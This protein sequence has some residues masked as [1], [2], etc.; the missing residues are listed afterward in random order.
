MGNESSR[1]ET[2]A[3]LDPEV[4]PRFLALTGPEH[5]G[6]RTY[7]LSLLSELLDESDL[8]VA[9]PGPDGARE[10]RPFL[11][12]MPS[13]SPFRAV[14]LDDVDFLSEP[15]QD[16]W[17]KLCE[18]PPGQ[19]CIVAVASDLSMVLPALRSRVVREIRWG[20]LS[21]E[22]MV[23]Y[24][25]AN[26]ADADPVIARLCGRRPGLFSAMSST[27]YASLFE[28][29]CA[30]LERP[31]FTHPIPEVVKSLEGKRSPRRTAVSG[32]IRAAALSF[33]CDVLRRPMVVSLL[34][35]AASL[36][37]VPA[38]NAEIHWYNAMTSAFKM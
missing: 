6:K 2:A 29:V 5:V 19:T 24:A 22:E 7:V 17:L 38:S 28:S 37:R 27:E 23:A 31:S 36:V 14:V 25:V 12:S 4:L 10:A 35:F 20:L 16:S 32:V 18:E 30:A 3:A 9:D 33:S 11:S 26:E 1:L 8:L 13:N 34:R 15:A 21:E